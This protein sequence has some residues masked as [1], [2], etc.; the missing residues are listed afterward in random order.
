[1]ENSELLV[2]KNKYWLSEIGYLFFKYQVGYETYDY[3]SDAKL[4]DDGV[5]LF[6]LNKQNIPYCCLVL[7][8]PEPHDKIFL[9][10]IEDD[11]ESRLMNS[12]ADFVLF[13][14]INADEVH[15]FDLPLL[16]ETIE[17]QYTK[18]DW[19]ELPAARKQTQSTGLL[20][21]KDDESIAFKNTYKLNKTI[22][23]KARRIYKFRV[24]RLRLDETKVLP[25][26]RVRN[27][28]DSST[29]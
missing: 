24:G 12:I 3:G 2:R 4:V 14:D 13:V 8:N 15:L 29:S 5:D 19:K 22:A 21:P 9:P 26:S 6:I 10:L 11:E 1:M 17:H 20:I 7:G 28:E 18:G 25:I 16:K 27:Y 23:D